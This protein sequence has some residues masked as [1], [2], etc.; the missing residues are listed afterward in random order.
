VLSHISLFARLSP[1]ILFLFAACGDSITLPPWLG[2]WQFPKRPRRTRSWGK[3]A[4]DEFSEA[5][6]QLLARRAGFRCSICQLP[7][8]G[9]HSEADRAVYLGEASHIHSAAPQGPRANL[10]MT[11]DERSSLSNGIHLC[12]VHAKLIDM[13]VAG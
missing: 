8:V 5:T 2:S 3:H 10:A 7:T 4:R 11:P 13:D 6:K 9:P 12:K 1:R